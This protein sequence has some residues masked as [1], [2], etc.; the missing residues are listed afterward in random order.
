MVRTMVATKG[1][2]LFGTRQSRLRM[3]CVRHLCQA[4]PGS[5]A[6]IAFVRPRWSSEMTSCTP[7]RPRA[8]RSREEDPPGGLVLAREGVEA[9]DLAVAVGVHRAWP[10]RRRSARCA[11]P[12]ARSPPGRRAT[13]RGRD[14]RPGAGSGRRPP[15]RRGSWPSPRPGSSRC[16]RCRASSRGRRR[17]AWRRRARSTRRSRRPGPAR[18]ACRRSSSQSG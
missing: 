9:E 17:G 2:A 13:G 4:A 18:R 15:P 11:P 5:S 14:R 7:E 8:A 1:W 16:P 6:S 10:R 12:R 3:K